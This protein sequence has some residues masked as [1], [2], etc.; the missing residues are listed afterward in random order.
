MGFHELDDNPQSYSTK[1]LPFTQYNSNR[2]LIVKSNKQELEYSYV[3]SNK[4]EL[5]YSYH[6]HNLYEQNRIAFW[7]R[8]KHWE[9]ES[10]LFW[11]RL[12]ERERVDYSGL[13]SKR[14]REFLIL[15]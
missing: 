13:D 9:K 11:A 3:K 4:Q 8:L 14:E 6:V 10:G 12:K 7:A 1:P 2:D 15:G 5:E